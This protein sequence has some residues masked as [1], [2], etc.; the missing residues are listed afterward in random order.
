VY[1]SDADQTWTDTDLLALNKKRLFYCE[2]YSCH[3]ACVD[4][5]GVL[6]SDA[7]WAV[8]EHVLTFR[9]KDA[10]LSSRAN[11]KNEGATFLRNVGHVNLAAI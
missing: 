7:A 3:S 1:V 2:I 6:G 5:S 8:T 4:D 10:P 9:R 11:L